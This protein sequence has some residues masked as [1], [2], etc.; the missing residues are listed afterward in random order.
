MSALAR[1]LWRF[2]L[3]AAVIGSL[4]AAQEAKAEESAP[5]PERR[6]VRF[7]DLPD[8]EKKEGPHP[9]DVWVYGRFTARA[10]LSGGVFLASV[11]EGI[12]LPD[13][14]ENFSIVNNPGDFVFRRVVFRA[15]LPL[16]EIR[17]GTKFV[18]PRDRPAKLIEVARVDGVI[19]RLVLESAPT[20]ESQDG[21]GRAAPRPR[22]PRE[23]S[24]AGGYPPRRIVPFRELGSIAKTEGVH[25]ENLW[26]W[27]KFS[28][29]SNLREGIV[30]ATLAGMETRRALE[31]A[32]TG[33]ATFYLPYLAYFVLG[34]EEP[35]HRIIFRVY[36]PRM[37]RNG[38]VIEI[39]KESP[40]RVKRIFTAGGI[41][42]WLDLDPPVPVAI[43][44]ELGES[45]NGGR[46]SA[47]P[48]A[49]PRPASVERVATE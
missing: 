22:S 25:P 13:W 42:V 44:I 12:N 7:G 29:R 18:I 16:P 39:T 14:E 46:E 17:R 36:Q 40:A 24:G 31:T 6:V 47:P 33:A 35:V 26:T 11:N 28:A 32:I 1:S 41:L 43:P 37:I 38:D 10:A 30:S 23:G 49:P 20:I 34:A 27:G 8:L 4:W 19:A 48:A 2:L 9:R 45:G 15:G 21:A 3:V 5:A